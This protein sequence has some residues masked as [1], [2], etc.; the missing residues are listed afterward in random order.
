MTQKNRRPY[1]RQSYLA[2]ALIFCMLPAAQAIEELS[3]A[4]LSETTGE[5]IAILPEDFKLVFQMPNDQSTASSY[6]RSLA[7]T[8]AL[9]PSQFD[10]GFIRLIPVGEDYSAYATST[11][12]LAEKRTKAD[13]FIYGM[14]L[15]KTN[16]NLNQRFSNEGFTW[17]SDVN[18]WVIRAATQANVKQFS[19]S[20]NGDIGYLAVEAPLA[21]EGINESDNDIKLGLWL[22]AFSRQWGSSNEVDWVTGAPV[23]ASDLTTD[24]RM[25][26]QFIANGLSL[27]GSQLRLFQTQHSTITQQ[28]NTLGIASLIRMNTDDDPA[29]LRFNKDTNGEATN[30]IDLNKR[31][32]RLNTA[33]INDG[34]AS[35]PALDR[36]YAPLF[37]QREGLYLYSPN[38]NLVLGNMYQPFIV[39]SQGNNI[40]LELTRI[41]NVPEIY[42]KIY[43]DYLSETSKAATLCNV[44]SCGSQTT[45]INNV[46]YQAT[47]ATHGSISIG[48]V[49]VNNHLLEAN[50]STDATGVVFRGVDNAAP[51]NLGSVT[52]DGILIQHLKFRT[53]GL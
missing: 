26:L 5:G 1:I 2:L 39:G 34:T 28:N 23:V 43:T 29:L 20:N 6:N 4:S 16:E 36:S 13:I 24:Q 30:L 17:G 7:G 42:N 10:T 14:A 53:T 19:D 40:I 11:E 51:V 31:A 27:S 12:N 9:D 22:D 32:W 35:T 50:K 45:T 38:I 37:D 18:P 3:D 52:M 44:A 47:T 8:G 48:S 41:P 25:R 33:A 15:S 46:K 49:A 21:T